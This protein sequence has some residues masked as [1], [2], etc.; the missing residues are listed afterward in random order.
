MK[1]GEMRWRVQSGIWQTA[2]KGH[3][4]QALGCSSSVRNT[5]ALEN[6]RVRKTN[7]LYNNLNR[8]ER[9]VGA[10]ACPVRSTIVAPALQRCRVM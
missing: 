6:Q 10:E 2:A 4:G 9:V 8:R 5:R 1:L 3:L 7:K